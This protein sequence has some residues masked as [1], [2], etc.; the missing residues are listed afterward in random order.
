M[1]HT[2]NISRPNI[3]SPHIL[4]APHHSRIIGQ[5]LDLDHKGGAGG[6]R[7]TGKRRIK[8]RGGRTRR[9]K[10]GRKRTRRA[11]RRTRRAG[12]RRRTRR[13]GRRTRRAGRRRRTHKGGLPGLGLI[14]TKP[15]PAVPISTKE[16]EERESFGWHK[17]W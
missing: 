17:N 9:R 11:G 1:V 3:K 2:T 13:A 5:I 15:I 14:L 6:T 12:S 16:K 7:R 8:R 10:A 4:R